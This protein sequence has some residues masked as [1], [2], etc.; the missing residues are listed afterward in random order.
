MA[1]S[2]ICGIRKQIFFFDWLRISTIL[3]PSQM[4][5]TSIVSFLG[6][7]KPSTEGINYPNFNREKKILPQFSRAG[8]T[9]K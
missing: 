5:A 3:K 2:I 1:K 8:L 7:R 4:Q 9:N 6:G